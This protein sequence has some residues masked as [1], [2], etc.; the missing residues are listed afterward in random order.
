MSV[1]TCFYD[2]FIAIKGY[3][4]TIQREMKCGCLHVGNSVIV[5]DT[6]MLLTDVYIF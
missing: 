5:S 1:G 6:D 2:N 3:I 4:V